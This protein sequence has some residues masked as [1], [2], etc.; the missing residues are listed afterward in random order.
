MKPKYFLPILLAGALLA[1]C[2]NKQKTETE[3]SAD[4]NQLVITAAQFKENGMEL[5]KP[6]ARSFTDEVACK[7]YITSPPNARAK[8]TSLVAGKIVSL[9]VRLGDYVTR[10]KVICTITGI[11]FIDIQ[12]EY[13]ET[14]ARFVKVKADYERSKALR[15]ENIGAEKD[16][17]S[18]QSEYRALTASLNAQRAKLRS[19]QLN[20]SEIENG[21]FYNSYAITAPISGYITAISAVQGQY[22]DIS[23]EIAEIVDVKQAQLKLSVFE[24]D[25]YKLKAGQ[26]VRFNV[27]GS[28]ENWQGKLLTV[29]KTIQPD[30]KTADCIAQIQTAAQTPLVNEG[31]VQAYVITARTDLQALPNTALVKSDGAM[32]VYQLKEKKND[33]YVFEKKEVK[34]TRSNEEYSAFSEPL[35]DREVIVKGGSTL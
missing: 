33:S 3:Q 10:G 2:G 12:K 18:V 21:R 34:I 24:N 7:G 6:A 23:T 22:A 16:F 31:F 17:V 27:A 32:Y 29:G 13:A 20:V 1:S 19:L 15:E 5:G 26:A 11:D 8:V 25:V 35:P 9:P 28:A 4:E 14:S 30:T